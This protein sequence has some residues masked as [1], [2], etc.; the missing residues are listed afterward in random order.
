[1]TP[2]DDSDPRG[3]VVLHPEPALG[4]DGFTSFLR[5]ERVQPCPKTALKHSENVV[6]LL[7][8]GSQPSHASALG[9]LGLLRH[10]KVY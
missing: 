6:E 5:F 4:D 10:R 2:A 8:S 3:T 7:L 1:M 9:F